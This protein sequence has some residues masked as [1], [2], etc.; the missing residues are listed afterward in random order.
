MTAHLGQP[1]VELRS[2]DRMSR[3]EFHQLYEQT[4]EE[5]R[6]ELISGIV[7]VTASRTPIPQAK[8]TAAHHFVSHRAANEPPLS[9]VAK[10][11]PRFSGRWH[12]SPITPGERGQ[13]R[14]PRDGHRSAKASWRAR[15][16]GRDPRRTP[17]LILDAAGA[18]AP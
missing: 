7:Y 1:P 13:G 10:A 8:S 12:E 15:K 3:E 17:G 14:P 18:G 4:P 6:D 16:I 11:A 5:C 2:G 9:L